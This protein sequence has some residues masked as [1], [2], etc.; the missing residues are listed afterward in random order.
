MPCDVLSTNHNVGENTDGFQPYLY[1]LTRLEIIPGPLE[2]P[3]GSAAGPWIVAAFS[4]PLHAVPD[5]PGQ[6]GPASVIVRWQLDTAPQALH[7]KFD[8]VVSKR[9]TNIQAKVSLETEVYFAL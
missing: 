3:A 9:N 5:E 7:P 1:N 2:I 4:S 8:E 6:Q